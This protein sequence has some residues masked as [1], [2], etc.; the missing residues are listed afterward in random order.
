MEDDDNNKDEVKESNEE[1]SELEILVPVRQVARSGVN[2]LVEW[3][4]GDDLRRATIPA[5]KVKDGQAEA[6]TL[7]AGFPYGAPWEEAGFTV[8]PADVARE[9]RRRGVWTEADLFSMAPEA[10]KAIIQAFSGVWPELVKLARQR[11]SK[12]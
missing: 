6:A 12:Q 9:L 3:A 4:D 10:K 8:S 5:R 7:E 1:P 11:R 2:V